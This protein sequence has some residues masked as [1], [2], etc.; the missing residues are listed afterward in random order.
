MFL[1]LHRRDVLSLNF[2]QPVRV[3][4]SNSPTGLMLQVHVKRF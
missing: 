4:E 1:H 2:S 3:R